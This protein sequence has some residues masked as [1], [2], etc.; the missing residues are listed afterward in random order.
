MYSFDIPCRKVINKDKPYSPKNIKTTPGHNVQQIQRNILPAYFYS[1]TPRCTDP[2][3]IIQR[4]I[5]KDAVE[6]AI[7]DYEKSKSPQSLTKLNEILKS[8]GV[9]RGTI[10]YSGHDD[11]HN[12]F[13]Y[14]AS[15]LPELFDTIDK[16]R[17]YLLDRV[18]NENEEQEKDIRSR[19]LFGNEFT[20]RKK[21]GSFDFDHN[22]LDAQTSTMNDNI[23]KANIIVKQ[24]PKI[25][26]EDYD[27]Y[28]G[29]KKTPEL[30][31]T[32]IFSSGLGKKKWKSTLYEACRITCVNKCTNESWY[33]NIDLDPNCIEIQTQPISYD[34]FSKLK[35][36]INT[37]I[38]GVAERLGLVADTDSNTGGGGHIS[39]D[40]DTA[41]GD[42]AHYLRNFLV[43]YA[44][45][46]NK[47]PNIFECRDEV[48]APILNELGICEKFINAINEFDRLYSDKQNK[49]TI[50]QLVELIQKRVYSGQFGSALIANLCTGRLSG[51]LR[52]LP[53]DLAYHYQA[54]NLEHVNDRQGPG[55][56]EMRRFNA[57]ISADETIKQFNFLIDLLL[58]S[59]NRQ[60]LPSS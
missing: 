50:Q 49:P 18:M 44:R 19:V 14:E 28:K 34:K 42:N 46:S 23:S 9:I 4:Y 43:A 51:K 20:F 6:R 17:A 57:Q 3:P 31:A 24:W 8:L 56:I 30:Y 47:D 55:R 39:F 26:S 36:L 40:V 59:R 58:K 11:V 41:F 16:L 22:A 38:F 54:V 52:N 13:E 25:I 27:K 60:K 37:A 35:D 15:K 29:A 21:D 48:N 7:K 32:Y 12:L 45:E 10:E 2:S 33:F 5:D 53:P 1:V